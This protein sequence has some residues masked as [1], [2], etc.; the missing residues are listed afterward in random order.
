MQYNNHRNEFSLT[1]DDID[2]ADDVKVHLS[3]E[4]KNKTLG[5]CTWFCLVQL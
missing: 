3:W 2:K 1:S 5:V 4:M